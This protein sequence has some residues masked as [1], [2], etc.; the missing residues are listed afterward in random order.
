M[1]FWLIVP[2]VVLGLAAI[3]LGLRGRK[4]AG[5]D[6]RGRELAFAGI[7]LGIASIVLVPAMHI[8][9]E[10]G[11]SFGRECAFKPTDPHC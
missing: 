3:F 8:A 9:S 7:A 2:V 11:E 1:A 6:P 4:R 5:A 10:D